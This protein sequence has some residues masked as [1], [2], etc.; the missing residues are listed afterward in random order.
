MKINWKLI[1]GRR[2]DRRRRDRGGAQQ[3]DPRPG[4]GR[5]E[6]DRPSR[7]RMPRRR[8][9]TSPGPSTPSRR[10][11]GTARSRSTPARSRPSAWRRSP[12][13]QQTEPTTLTL[14]GTTDYDPAKV[15]VVRTPVRQPRRQGSGRPGLDRQEGR[16]AARAVQHRPGRG[17]ERL[18]GGASASGPT[19]RRCYDYKTPLAKDEYAR[20]ERS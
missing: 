15:T 7:R 20:P 16:P 4:A 18:R 19:T 6:A 2:A 3:M 11:P 5:L 12:V 8:S 1:A 17:Q 14:F 13:L 10:P 9:R